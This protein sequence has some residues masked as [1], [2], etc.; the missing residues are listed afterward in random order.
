M[1]DSDSKKP[2]LWVV[3]NES[4]DIV[5]SNYMLTGDS[6][7]EGPVNRGR[8]VAAAGQR[9]IEMDMSEEMHFADSAATFHARIATLMSG[10][11]K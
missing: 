8:P 9:A 6:K 11:T 5:G 7:G 3:V 4:G 1:S 10:R 2:S